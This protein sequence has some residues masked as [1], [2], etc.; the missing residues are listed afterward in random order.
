M[1]QTIGTPIVPIGL[2][3]VTT[4]APTTP[5]DQAVAMSKDIPDLISKAQ[6][7][8]PALASKWTGTALI[9]SKTVWGAAIALV[10][11][12]IAKRYT[13]GWDQNTVDIVAGLIDLG[14]I[15]GLRKITDTPI[16]G[17]L[18]KATPA[19]AATI[20]AQAAPAKGTTV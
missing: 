15:A 6:T 9:Q 17:W 11:T 16:T 18:R 12:A 20:A 3:N 13:L 7:F 2:P 8:D 19:E 5:G 10:L 1:S 14:I 4:G